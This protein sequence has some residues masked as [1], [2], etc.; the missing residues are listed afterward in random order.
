MDKVNIGLAAGIV[1]RLLSDSE[2]LT[3][4]QLAAETSLSPIELA[5]AIGWL[6]REDK[7]EIFTADG[8]EK[9]Q[10]PNIQQFY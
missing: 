9:Y 10:L 7:I 4:N 3:F 6:A 5:A 8:E 2:S 1:W